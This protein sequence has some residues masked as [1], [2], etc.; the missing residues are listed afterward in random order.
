M[1][2]ELLVEVARL[3]ARVQEPIET[4]EDISAAEELILSASDEA[5]FHGSDS[6]TADTVPPIVKNVI[7]GACQR[8]FQNPGFLESE[9]ADA[10]NL[11]R[12]DEGMLTVDFTPE[13]VKR[14]EAAAGK[15]RGF[16]AMPVARADRFVPRSAGHCDKTVYVPIIAYAPGAKPFPWE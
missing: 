6:W 11:K 9:R 14:I 5:R 7:L 2:N 12:S 1:I 13:E 15:R 4:P 8:A 3:A 10:V 16:G